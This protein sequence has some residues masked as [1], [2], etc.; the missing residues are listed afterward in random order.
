MLDQKAIR[1]SDNPE[2]E[3]YVQAFECFVEANRRC[4]EQGAR[5][6]EVYIIPVHAVQAMVEQ[7]EELM[8]EFSG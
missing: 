4:F 5:R 6:G 2:A 3:R 8:R 7:V 1:Q